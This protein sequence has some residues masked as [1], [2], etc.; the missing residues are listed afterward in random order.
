M[1]APL[2][3]LAAASICALSLWATGASAKVHQVFQKEID[4]ICQEV[5]KA[6][7]IMDVQAI[8]A[9]E[10][11]F[12]NFASNARR[13]AQNYT[14][15][16]MA[17][18][19]L[20]AATQAREKLDKDL[21]DELTPGRE[22]HMRETRDAANSAVAEVDGWE[23]ER[24][25]K[26]QARDLHKKDSDNYK[27]YQREIDQLTRKIDAGRKPA[28]D[29]YREAK[30]KYD[31]RLQKIRQLHADKP[32]VYAAENHAEK[33]HLEAQNE[34]VRLNTLAD[35][36]EETAG[37]IVQCID[38]R[39]VE[40]DPNSDTGLM[41]RYFDTI[42]RLIRT[43]EGQ[44]R[45]A[46]G[47][48]RQ[49]KA[50]LE[51]IKRLA[52]DIGREARE[53]ARLRT[54]DP[55]FVQQHDKVIQDAING[56]NGAAAEVNQTRMRAIKAAADA[57]SAANAVQRDPGAA[58]AA[59]KLTD[60]RQQRDAAQAEVGKAAAALQRIRAAYAAATLVAAQ[61]DAVDDDPQVIVSAIETRLGH[62]KQ[63][64]DTM[65][66]ATRRPTPWKDQVDKIGMAL[67][68]IRHQPKLRAFAERHR[69]RVEKLRD[70]HQALVDAPNCLA[71][72]AADAAAASAALSAADSVVKAIPAAAR[73]QSPRPTR[74]PTTIAGI[75]N[76]ARAVAD[77]TARE[78]VKAVGCVNG[79]SI[80]VAPPPPPPPPPPPVVAD[81]IRC[82]YKRPDGSTIEVT[83]YDE[84]T[85]PKDI[86]G[87]FVDAKPAPK[88]DMMQGFE[89]KWGGS[90]PKLEYL[91][92]SGGVNAFSIVGVWRSDLSSSAAKHDWTAECKR[93]SAGTNVAEC[94]GKGKYSDSYKYANYTM[95]FK[96]SVGSDGKHMSLNGV[97][98]TAVFF[99]TAGEPRRHNDTISE[100]RPFSGSFRR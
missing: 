36:L 45:V 62:L 13:D 74:S 50:Q 73:A 37:E 19:V 96:L 57:C 68:T 76:S 59:A 16:F 97:Y 1:S 67:D 84:R 12:N 66:T 48:C 2:T 53:A 88:P 43:A 55:A 98:V 14:G 61:L 95:T 11:R 24:G 6:Q 7:T 58:D 79:V 27:A 30:Q 38:S 35:E 69:E 3:R 49:M 40:L 44:L 47:Q 86:P 51:E 32:A 9:R 63:A 52:A 18:T 15:V 91:T 56:A 70:R 29:A 28:D 83:I 65:Q 42:E 4:R 80:A 64:V 93:T 54:A 41:Q 23:K 20:D 75:Y 34:Q 78:A 8:N 17:K 26:Q 87:K 72:L 39:I 46:Q 90:D 82:R 60:A 22:Q 85:C 89:G 5:R 99:T 10:G 77:D 21:G 81:G 31:A 33:K 25:E 71:A 92:I 94:T 100:G